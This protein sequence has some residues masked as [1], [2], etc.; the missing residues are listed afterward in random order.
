MKPKI[1]ICDDEE[2]V[3]ESL[4]LILEKDYDV[5]IATNGE[6]CLERLKNFTADLIMLDIKMP[7]QS[8]MDILKKIKSQNPN[9]KVVMVTGYRLVD[10][11]TEAVKAGADDYLIKPFSSKDILES[12]KKILK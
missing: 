7:K 8:G 6:E 11:A 1:I 4:K 2:G 9:A 10:V 3:R 12:V 5:T